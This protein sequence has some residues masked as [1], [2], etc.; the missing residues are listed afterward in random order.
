MK[1]SYSSADESRLLRD[2]IRSLLLHRVWFFIGMQ[3]VKRRYRRSFI[4]PLWILLNLGV[5]V[6]AIG[7]V[8]GVMFGQ[9]LKAFLPYLM[10]GF[11][12]WG[13]ISASMVD[14][15]TVFISAEGYIKQFSYPKQIYILRAIVSSSMNFAMGL[16]AV[17]VLQ[18]VLGTFEFTGW[19]LAIPG[20]VLLYMALLG[21]T[22][23]FS[24]LGVAFRDLPHA[25]A[26]V[27]QVVFY[28]TPIVFPISVLKSHNLEFVYLI[29]P[30][31]HLIDVVRHPILT[32][33]LAPLSSYGFVFGYVLI[34]YCIAWYVASRLDKKV[35]FLL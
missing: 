5:Y 29:N 32:A 3:D 25:L 31:Y 23:I 33:S 16:A 14:A 17:A 24:Y 35:V 30:I 21:Q 7:F 13:L 34:V 28:L 2:V 20:I 19:L 4:G 22:T 15:G 1:H 18:I 27:L 12:T 9:D 8:Y 10:L 26:G 6:G 11:V